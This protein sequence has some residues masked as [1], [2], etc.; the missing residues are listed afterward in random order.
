MIGAGGEGE[1][2]EKNS[3]EDL[4]SREIERE[5]QEHWPLYQEGLIK[6]WRN[7]SLVVL[8]RVESQYKDVWQNLVAKF[9]QKSL[10]CDSTLAV[11]FQFS[12]LK[13]F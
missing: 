4:P 9:C 6:F 10:Y 2:G 13:G 3:F 11:F 7:I 1:E 5:R 12:P 8:Y